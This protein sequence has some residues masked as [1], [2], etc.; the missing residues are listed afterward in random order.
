MVGNQRQTRKESANSTHK[1]LAV[2]WLQTS[3]ALRNPHLHQVETL[4]QP[5]T[6]T[7]L[8]TITAKQK[9]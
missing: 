7:Q 6:T 2:Q 1:K 5:I 3:F 9:R 4:L 8:T